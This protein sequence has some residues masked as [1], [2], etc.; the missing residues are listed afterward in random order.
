M[1]H[2]R[3]EI[4]HSYAAM[5]RPEDTT[6]GG[7]AAV[8]R[9]GRR[10]RQYAEIL[11]LMR[12]L[13]R[14]HKNLVTRI[15]KAELNASF[16]EYE[17]FQLLKMFEASLEDGV[18]DVAGD[19][20]SVSSLETQTKATRPLRYLAES[21]STSLEIRSRPDGTADVRIDGGKQ[22]TL[23]PTLADL[24]TALS[25]DNGFS[26]DT[27]VG[28]KTLGEIAEYLA[29]RSGKPVTKRSITQNVYRLRRELFDRGGVNP[30]LVQTN[31]RR[32]VR[33]ALRRKASPVI[34]SD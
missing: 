22:F 26:E 4:R 13:A 25:I 19:V 16:I 33:F 1:R 2:S 12:G 14:R 6:G 20:A 34:K 27:L 32:G 15:S 11:V 30:Y 24:M 18:D 3:H 9:R 8:E 31:R 17:L 21:G 7:L 23:P 5:D 10:A 28:W 29:G